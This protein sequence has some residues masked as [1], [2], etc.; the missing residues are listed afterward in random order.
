MSNKIDKLEPFVPRVS[1]GTADDH[2][3]S[4]KA[5]GRAAIDSRGKTVWEWKTDTGQFSTEVSTKRLKKLEASELSLE[6]TA[7][8][9]QPEV[10][11][12]K[13]K[14]LPCGGFNPYD[15]GALST[16]KPVATQAAA[17]PSR[18]RPVVATPR[19]PVSLLGRLRAWL[20]RK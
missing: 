9:K 17:T 6:K 18:P 5:S 1:T 14:P 13:E 7:I 19:R 11:I 12:P 4:A 20:D 2:A 15:R 16:A 3:S 10:Q 8:V